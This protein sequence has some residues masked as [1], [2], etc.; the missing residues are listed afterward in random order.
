MNPKAHSL[1]LWVFWL[2]ILSGLPLLYLWV[3]ADLP[4]EPQASATDY[5]PLVPLLVS[6][7]LRWNLLPRQ[8]APQRQLPL[9]MVG[10]F[11]AEAAGLLGLFV[12]PHMR[13]TYTVLAILTL[14]QYCPAT[15][16][17]LTG[18]QDSFRA[19]TTPPPP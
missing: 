2:S 14:L 17:P 19:T 3:P 6:V 7:F 9:F 1:L 8:R 15:L 10:L 12:V 13:Q 16:K 11:L 18:T 5:L 4:A